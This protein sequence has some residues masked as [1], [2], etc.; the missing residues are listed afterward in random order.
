MKP[1]PIWFGIAGSQVPRCHAFVSG[2]G[3]G[4]AAH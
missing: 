4:V 2:V 3:A 1:A